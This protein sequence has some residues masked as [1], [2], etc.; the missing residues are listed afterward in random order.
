MTVGIGSIHQHLCM[1]VWTWMCGRID[2]LFHRAV[3]VFVHSCCTRLFS[4]FTSMPLH[5]F[6]LTGTKARLK[7]FRLKFPVLHIQVLRLFISYSLW[8]TLYLNEQKL[9]WN[10]FKHFR[11]ILQFERITT[12]DQKVHVDKVLELSLNSSTFTFK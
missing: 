10:V 6:H 12:V 5:C 7:S 9:L 11:G 8:S 2:F 3:W 1:Y 4:Y